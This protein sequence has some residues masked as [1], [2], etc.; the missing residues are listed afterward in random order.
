MI[1]ATAMATDDKNIMIDKNDDDE[2]FQHLQFEETEE[3]NNNKGSSIFVLTTENTTETDEDTL[4]EATFGDLGVVGMNL[5]SAQSLER[6][7][8]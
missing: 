4:N 5:S 6:N 1:T 8:L 2:G 3:R 7:I